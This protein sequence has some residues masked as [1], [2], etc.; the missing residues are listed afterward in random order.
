MP[1]SKQCR[2]FSATEDAPGLRIP[3]C[4][5]LIA[6]YSARE[7]KHR[8]LGLWLFKNNTFVL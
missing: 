2:L 4:H 1:S 8:F 6:M 3:P 7:Q 5:V